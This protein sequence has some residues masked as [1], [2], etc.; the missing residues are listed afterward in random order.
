MEEEWLNQKKCT[1]VKQQVV[2]TSITP[3]KVTEKE[4]FLR[5]HN[6]KTFRTAGNAP[7]AGPEKKSSTRWPD[8]NLPPT[9]TAKYII[10]EEH[11]SK[12][13]NNY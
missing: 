9:P 6:L 7:F 8:P 2:D 5:A 11:I 1:N 4:K 12:S 10:S 3:I 13:N